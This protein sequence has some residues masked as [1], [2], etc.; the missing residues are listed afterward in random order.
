M[1]IRLLLLAAFVASHRQ[2]V[3]EATAANRPSADRPNI[4]LVITD[5]Q[6]Y[7]DLAC[8]GNPIIRTPHLD[9]LHGESVRLTDYHVSP[10]CSPTRAALLSGHWT[11]HTGAWHTIAGRSI[12]FED[13]VLLPEV[14]A[15]AGYATAMFGKWHLG[16]NAPSRPLDHG[17]D[18]VFIHGGGGVGQTPDY[19]NNAYFDGHYFLNGEPVA[20]SGHCTDVWFDAA[21]EYI[22]EKSESDQPFFVY[23]STNAPH[24]PMHSR[25]DYAEHYAD[26]P[27]TT[28]NFLGMIEHID[29]RVGTLRERLESLG[30]ADNTIFIYTTDNGTAAGS[31][32]FN[33]KMKGKKGSNYEGGHRVPAF[34]HW[35][36]GGLNGGRDVDLLTA[37]VDM[38]PTL[39]DL[40][41]VSIPDSLTPHGVSLAKPLRGQEIALAARTLVTDSQRIRHPEKWRNTAVMRDQWRLLNRTELY[42]IRRDPGQAT[43]VASD[44]PD[45]VASLTKDYDAWWTSLRPRLAKTA[46]IQ[47]GN[48]AE[49]SA[50]LT[51]HDWF[52]EAM[53]PW[54]QQAIRA[55]KQIDDPAAYWNV[56]FLKAGRY[57]FRLS[58]WPGES[59]LALSDAAEAGELVPGQRPFRATPGVAVDLDGAAATVT[60]GEQSSEAVPVDGTQPFVEIVAT[61]GDVGPTT[62][63]AFFDKDGVRRNAY[64]VEVA[65]VESA[66]SASATPAA[67]ATTASQAWQDDARVRRANERLAALPVK[68]G[69][70]PKTFKELRLGLEGV[71]TISRP[72]IAP[73]DGTRV[74]RGLPYVSR[75]GKPLHA[76]AYLPAGEGPHP[77]VMLVHGGGWKGGSRAR[78]EPKGVWLA[79]RG[80][81]AVA[82]DYRL[83]GQAAYPALMH[84]LQHA[85]A[86]LR[87]DAVET[88]QLPL[89]PSKLILLGGSAGATMVALQATSSSVDRLRD[90]ELAPSANLAVDGAVV[91]AGPTDTEGQNARERS[92]SPESNYFK[93]FR[94]SIE[95]HPAMYRDFNPSAHASDQ[96]PPLLFIDENTGRQSERLRSVLDQPAIDRP[97]EHYVFRNVLHGSW[98]NQPWFE[99]TMQTTEAFA[100]RVWSNRSSDSSN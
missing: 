80:I 62:L 17:F 32:I 49:P 93:L 60:I 7:G 84:D 21:E 76:D 87:T 29:D 66:N 38:L 73:I 95:D 68:K 51:S 23:L 61:V 41:G 67:G 99:F 45:V 25:P 50:R 47:L 37:H 90:P 33:A 22:A 69:G 77:V 89:D 42:D 74:L 81:A 53:T 40:A 86:W 15:D 85:I 34:F 13:E 16:D 11:N 18:H 79:N 4:V 26:Q 63:S 9:R 3:S 56:T 48:G 59:G 14:L 72:E 30:V 100:R 27:K 58:R 28:Q 75:D 24:S 35:P 54:N 82:I 91:I 2:T 71:A 88:R 52:A 5:D 98:N 70:P 94:G 10:T 64:Y 43:N 92:V 36:A 83:S 65:L 78:D 96:T 46:F 6:G 1:F 57:R 39:L 20:V 12:L 97:Y 31:K 19:W 8:H 55:A 44:H